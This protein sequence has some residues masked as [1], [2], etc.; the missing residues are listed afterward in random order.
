MLDEMSKALVNGNTP[1]VK[2][3]T[4]EVLR[5]GV[6]PGVIVNKGLIPGMDI[7]GIRFKN[8]DISVPEVLMSARAMHAS[9]EILK[10]L[11]SRSDMEPLGLIAI[12]TVKGDIH[13]IG[14]NLVGM[15]LE[16]AGFHV[17]DMGIDVPPEAFVEIVREKKPDIL[18]LSAL[19]NS[20]LS[21]MK[22]TIDALESA[23]IK[24]EV[25]IMI[26][27]AP[28]TQDFADEIGAD[29]YA[30]DAREAVL[31]SKDILGAK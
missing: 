13:D 18:G 31:K 9:L 25:K 23:G 19:L 15:M 20:T 29:I 27:G 11:L 3:L 7:V 8:K 12:G 6:R 26:G 14:K 2:R 4:E 28:V 5:S 22:D 16:G 30:G 24:K 1:E 10:P 21:S 17:I